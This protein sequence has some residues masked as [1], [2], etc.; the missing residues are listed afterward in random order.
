[1]CS[2]EKNPISD[3][4]QNEQKRH[5]VLMALTS[6]LEGARLGEF[7][8]AEL[9]RYLIT[10][11]RLTLHALRFQAVAFRPW[12]L[13][14]HVADDD[15]SAYRIIDCVR[16]WGLS[17]GIVIIDSSGVTLEGGLM[18]SW[19]QAFLM[20]P[21]SNGDLSA[22]INRALQYSDSLIKDAE[23]S[24]SLRKDIASLTR[25]ER[26]VVYQ[27]VRGNRNS[28]IA[29]DL[30]IRS[31]TVKKYRSKAMEKLNV[32]TFS[33]LLMRFAVNDPN[34]GIN[35]VLA[36]WGR[37]PNEDFFMENEGVHLNGGEVDL[38]DSCL[39]SV[40]LLSPI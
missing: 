35:S 24:C 26:D 40:T 37:D 1:M 11:K 22:A 13:I 10:S 3:S 33:E 28:A 34:Y 6:I 8:E 19:A 2:I 21:V 32:K 12:A 23:K 15:L 36:S 20:A 16:H 30:N 27:L 9:G 14:L 29:K 31:D 38:V 17:C 7:F 4:S 5:G 25:R 39:Y 18:R